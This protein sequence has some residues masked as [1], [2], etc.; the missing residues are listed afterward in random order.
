MA[1]PETRAEA[2]DA[3]QTQRH[4]RAIDRSKLDESVLA[5]GADPSRDDGGVEARGQRAARA[6]RLVEELAQLLRGQPGRQVAEVQPAVPARHG[7]RVGL[8][9]RRR[10]L[11]DPSEAVPEPA[12]LRPG[13]AADLQTF[14]CDLV[15]LLPQMHL[16]VSQYL[17]ASV[18]KSKRS[19]MQ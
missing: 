7:V 19:A 3:I 10:E 6:E 8:D 15:S 2:R 5:V 4:R 13:C 1:H 18:S 14:M 16:S 12:G 9:G 11:L 17:V